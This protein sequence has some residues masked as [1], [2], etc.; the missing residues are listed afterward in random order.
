MKYHVDF[1]IILPFLIPLIS[2][3]SPI[4]S[5]MKSFLSEQERSL[6]VDKTFWNHWDSIFSKSTA[7][8]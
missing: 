7:H 8:N 5:I 2:L 3:T 4:L 6:N 1:Y